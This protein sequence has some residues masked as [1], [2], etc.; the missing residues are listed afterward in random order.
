MTET[1]LVNTKST[2][3]CALAVAL[4]LSLTFNYAALNACVYRSSSTTEILQAP[5]VRKDVQLNPNGS[6]D[7][8]VANT[9]DINTYQTV[10]SIRHNFNFS[11]SICT[12]TL[13]DEAC[14]ME[15]IDYHLLAMEFDRIYIYD[16]SETF[17][18]QRWWRKKRS[19]PVYS[20]VNVVH[21]PGQVINKERGEYAQGMMYNDCFERYGRDNDYFALIDTD[22]FVVPM[23]FFTNTTH[24][25][26]HGVLEEYLAP[27]GGALVVNW[28]I[29]GTGN[30]TRYSPIP[31]TKRFQFREEEPSGVV[32]T[33]AKITDFVRKRTPHSV[34][35]RH[36][37]LVRT[38]KE[39]G[40]VHKEQF[41]KMGATDADLPG[42]VLLLYHYRYRSVK[43]YRIRRCHR[44]EVNGS[45]KGCDKKINELSIDKNDHNNHRPG[46]VR[47]DLAW[48]ILTSRVSKYR[49]WDSSE[50]QDFE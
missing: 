1:R 37:A 20:R 7:G 19:H 31:T 35:V 27:F 44:G 11:V 5:I 15:W 12:I 18:L 9:T 39:P 32:K 4:F 17:E 22:E 33:I 29:F 13:D 36:P 47:D 30:K 43:E 21:F 10:P 23:K 34:F 48:R 25:S 49:A 6:N 50:W 42:D 46:T 14:M 40:Y 16:N 3:I 41:E 26:I 2:V 45:F 28:M 24:S 38:T 8:H